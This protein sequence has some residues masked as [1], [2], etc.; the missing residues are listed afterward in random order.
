MLIPKVYYIL[1]ES[2]MLINVFYFHDL[3][4]N[5][6]VYQLCFDFLIKLLGLFNLAA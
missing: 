6:N 4:F 1:K 5:A 3:K 2:M